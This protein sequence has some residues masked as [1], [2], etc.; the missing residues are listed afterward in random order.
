MFLHLN[1]A[2]HDIGKKTITD[3]ISKGNLYVYRLWSGEEI[4]F[5]KEETFQLQ[6]QHD[7]N[8][9]YPNTEI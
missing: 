2:I 6:K 7:V 5:R 8:S 9:D 1:I 4:T 3:K